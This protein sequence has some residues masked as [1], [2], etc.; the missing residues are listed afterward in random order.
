M[1]PS[2]TWQ[3]ATVI[4]LHGPWPTTAKGKKMAMPYVASLAIL[5]S[6]K[7]VKTSEAAPA[8]T[9]HT[10]CTAHTART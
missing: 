8:R 10:A 5:V 6:V 7:T 3:S 2:L 1:L 4:P 9:A